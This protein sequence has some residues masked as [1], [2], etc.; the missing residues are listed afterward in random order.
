MKLRD[1]QRLASLTAGCGLLGPACWST[2][3]VLIP[4]PTPMAQP[5]LLEDLALPRE[6]PTLSA[7]PSGN[8]LHPR[9]GHSH[10]LPEAAEGHSAP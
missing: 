1:R 7:L 6:E 10:P 3:A 4:S 8:E 2:P 9:P 5:E